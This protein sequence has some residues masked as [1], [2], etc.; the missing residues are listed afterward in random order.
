MLDILCCSFLF[1]GYHSITQNVKCLYSCSLRGTAHLYYTE[2]TLQRSIFLCRSVYAALDQFAI[3]QSHLPLVTQ[4]KCICICQKR[5]KNCNITNLH[6]NKLPIQAA[7]AVRGLRYDKDLG[8]ALPFLPLKHQV[9]IILVFIAGPQVHCAGR[10]TSFSVLL[11]KEN[12][13]FN[14]E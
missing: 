1:Q 7:E 9:R 4:G 5:N 10:V 12:P 11:A 14:I 13:K 2:V 3:G 6:L 8:L